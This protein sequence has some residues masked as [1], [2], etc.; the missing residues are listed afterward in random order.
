LIDKKG[1]FRDVLPSHS[2][3]RTL[4][5]LQSRQAPINGKATQNKHLKSNARFGPFYNYYSV[6]M[7]RACYHSQ[8]WAYTLG[9]LVHCLRLCMRKGT[10]WEICRGRGSR[11]QKY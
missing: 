2:L 1:N 11:R 5:I 10:S 3:S 9:I 7:D 4:R 6:E 8:Y